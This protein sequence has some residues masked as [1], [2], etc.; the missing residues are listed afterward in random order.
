[1]RKL[2]ARFVDLG[3]APGT[4]LDLAFA[5]RAANLAAI[6][7]SLVMAA[8][9]GMALA[10]EQNVGLALIMGLHLVGFLGAL[11]LNAAG[12]SDA[13]RFTGLAAA[14]SYYCTLLV[15]FGPTSGVR[16][17]LIAFVVYAVLIF[18]RIEKR[19]TVIAYLMIG[20]TFVI[21]ETLARRFGP[22]VIQTP[23]MGERANYFGILSVCAL[24]GYGMRYYQN[25]SFLAR[26][27]LG[28]A[29]RR[30][31]EL[32]GNVLPAPIVG[33]LQA[34]TGVIAESHGEAT[35]LFADLTGFSTLT[36]RLSPAHL[37]EVL[38]LIFSR[39][40]EAAVRHG[41]EKIKTIGDCYMAATG[42]LNEAQGAGAV[43]AMA[44]FSLEMVRI[45]GAT[46][47]EIG[48]PLGVR[49]GISTGPVISGVIGRRKYSFDVW[50]DTVNLA[51]RMESAGVAGRVQ[52]SEATYWRLQ[53]AFDFETRS[54]I[55]LKHD[56]QA[57][58][59]LLIGRKASRAA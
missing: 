44:D 11:A 32:L 35:V 16:V 8:A 46:A 26:Q 29:N 53:H 31:T 59:Y 41:I 54:T 4:P 6:L 58:A 1:M 40:D 23:A 52:V 27:E 36:R 9:V 30:I 55:V 20:A 15:A 50:G 2:L 56:E 43:E 57:V 39:Y 14:C 3:V 42:V 7:M 21:S 12:F 34:A 24:V 37:V 10:N 38:D 17:G 13:G 45:I 18:A 33:R 19:N 47:A 25:S 51:N 49:I 28:E 5:L 22:L 48:L